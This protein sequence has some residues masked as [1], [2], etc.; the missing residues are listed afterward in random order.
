MRLSED[1]RRKLATVIYEAAVIFYQ[2][3]KNI[4]KFKE[5]KDE[6]TKHEKKTGAVSIL[7][8]Q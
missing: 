6:E 4:E 2:D 8:R 7:P 1:D 3:P 5:W